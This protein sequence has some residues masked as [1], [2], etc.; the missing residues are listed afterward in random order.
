MVEDFNYTQIQCGYYTKQTS[1][2]CQM[3]KKGNFI[4]II[5]KI[6]SYNYIKLYLLKKSFNKYLFTHSLKAIVG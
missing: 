4:N 1:V 5:D 6:F 3:K 2:D